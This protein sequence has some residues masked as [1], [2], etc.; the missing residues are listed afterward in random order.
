TLRQGL[1]LGDQHDPGDF[2]GDGLPYPYAMALQDLMLQ[3]AGI[4]FGDLGVRQDAETRV[5]AIHR[6]LVA[7]DIGYLLLAGPDTPFDGRRDDALVSSGG[8]PDNGRDAQRI[9]AILEFGLVHV[10]CLKLF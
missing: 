8:E 6:F 1:D 5:Y 4:V 10:L 3:D 2:G 9:M 7:H